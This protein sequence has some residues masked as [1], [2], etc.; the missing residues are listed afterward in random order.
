MD[1]VGAT[2]IH[3]KVTN[4]KKIPNYTIVRWRITS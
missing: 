4:T 3:H 2:I 1:V